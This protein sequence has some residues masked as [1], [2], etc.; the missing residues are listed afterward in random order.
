M[1]APTSAPLPGDGDSRAL[2]DQP[3]WVTVPPARS[4]TREDHDVE[5]SPQTPGPPAADRITEFR[6]EIAQMR[7]SG[8][9]AVSERRLLVLGVVAVLAG[10]ALAVFGGIMVTNTTENVAANQRAYLATG[11]LLGIALVIAGAALFIRYSMARY[12]RFWLVRLV[13]ES[14][15]NTDRIVDAIREGR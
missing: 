4:T 5:Q 14:R 10:L 9:S 12:L 15:T 13:H 11:T 7:L 1:T 6:E 8:S 3:V 2:I